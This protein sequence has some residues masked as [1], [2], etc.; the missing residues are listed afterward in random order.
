M[1]ALALVI[2]SSALTLP[3]SAHAARDRPPPRRPRDGGHVVFLSAVPLAL[4]SF[5][6]TWLLSERPLRETAHIGRGEIGDELLAGFGQVEPEV[7]PELVARESEVPDPP[8]DQ[9]P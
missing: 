6:V 2:T 9:G 4:L 3:L 7:A 5:L 8:E 1:E